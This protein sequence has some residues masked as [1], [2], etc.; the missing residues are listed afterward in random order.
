MQE[1]VSVESSE[2]SSDDGDDEMEEMEVAAFLNDVE[3]DMF[4]ES[5]LGHDLDVL[6][7]FCGA[8][9]LLVPSTSSSTSKVYQDFMPKADFNAELYADYHSNE[10]CY[11]DASLNVESEFCKDFSCCGLVL[12]DLHELLQH[13]E[14]CHVHVEC[15]SHSENSS[16]TSSQNRRQSAAEMMMLN[17]HRAVSEE[18]VIAAFDDSF[19]PRHSRK[20]FHD[21]NALPENHSLAVTRVGDMEDDLGARLL[22]MMNEDFIRAG[23]RLKL[24]IDN[25]EMEPVDIPF[26]E[27]SEESDECGSDAE[28]ITEEDDAFMDHS[29]DMSTFSPSNAHL[30]SNPASDRRKKELPVF[31]DANGVRIEK[32]YTCSHEGCDKAYKNP[33]GL[34]YH[35]QHGHC[36]VGD[37]TVDKALRY[38]KPYVCNFSQCHKRY[39]NLNGLKYHMEKSHGLNKFESNQKATVIVKQTN[40]EYGINARSV[41]NNVLFAAMKEKEEK[42]RADN[43]SSDDIILIK[44]EEE[45]VTP[46]AIF[47]SPTNLTPIACRPSGPVKQHVPLA[48]KT[49]AV[50]QN[51]NQ[52]SIAPTL[53]KQKSS[54]LRM[55]NEVKTPS[56]LF[57]QQGKLVAHPHSQTQPPPVP[58]PTTQQQQRRI[59]YE[60]AQSLFSAAKIAASGQPLTFSLSNPPAYLKALAASGLLD[61]DK[62]M[63]LTRQQGLG[64]SSLLTP[65][66]NNAV[67]KRKR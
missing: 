17:H 56:F 28:S 13:Y 19:V 23:K 21:D 25:E 34:K 15:I 42:T 48:P 57:N 32:P 52:A 26:K 6:E 4:D 46:P 7:S 11:L 67:S 24:I 49:A 51:I 12:G 54:V 61:M 30:F 35:I 1:T 59:S 63:E 64:S 29:F 50:M 18:P 3:Q 8:E 60:H 39:K 27:Q 20:Q 22:D 5:A 55:P 65:E 47:I 45:T 62:V 14:D 66:N 9:D 37:E 40:A 33:N 31:V 58:Q 10:D 53:T 36:E 2:D 44:K 38:M 41:P 16:V 43:G